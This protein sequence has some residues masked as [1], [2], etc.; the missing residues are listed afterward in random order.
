MSALKTIGLN[1]SGDDAYLRTGRF[2]SLYGVWFRHYRVYAN[3]LLANAMP[4]VLEPLF[5]FTA[6][7]FGLGK[8]LPEFEEMPYRSYI[9]SGILV[10]S[11]MFT[12]IYECTFGTFVR[13]V[14]QKAYDAML[15]THLRISEI[16]TGEMVFTG[17][18]GAVFATIVMLV[19]AAELKGPCV[20]ST[21]PIGP[22]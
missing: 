17:T 15:G 3:T 8:Y 7:A 18:K 5:F 11:A 22:L 14:F 9:A 4:P 21:S 20:R 6:I 13:L 1:R 19:T 16:F 10:T 2:W 12:G